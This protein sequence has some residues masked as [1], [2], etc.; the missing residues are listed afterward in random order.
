MA[1]LSGG[2]RDRNCWIL[3]GIIFIVVGQGSFVVSRTNKHFG[4][5]I[6]SKVAW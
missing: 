6:V 3:H 5:S 1:N 2:T 4:D